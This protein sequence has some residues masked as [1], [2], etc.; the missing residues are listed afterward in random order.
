MSL[1][2]ASVENMKILLEDLADKLQVVNRT[3]MDP[4]DY[5]LEKY[6]D[7]KFMYDMV[8]QKGRL[9]ASETQAFIEELSLIRK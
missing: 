9:S 6:D 5:D 7:L 4:E 3:I 1:E 8:N 2:V